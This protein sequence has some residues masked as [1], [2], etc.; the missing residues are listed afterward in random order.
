MEMMVGDVVVVVVV[1]V[2]GLALEVKAHVGS[3]S[4]FDVARNFHPKASAR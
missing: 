3:R 2:I 4:R 1:A